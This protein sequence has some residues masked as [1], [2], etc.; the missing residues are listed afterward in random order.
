MARSLFYQNDQIQEQ[1]GK[2]YWNNGIDPTF[3][4]S[5]VWYRPGS[6]DSYLVWLGSKTYYVPDGTAAL[7]IKAFVEATLPPDIVHIILI[8]EAT[9]TV[10]I[11]DFG[12]DLPAEWNIELYNFGNIQG[13]KGT[14]SVNGGT[15][16]WLHRPVTVK[17][18]GTIAAGGGHGGRGG[19]GKDGPNVLSAGYWWT[20]YSSNSYYRHWNCEGTLTSPWTGSYNAVYR[21]VCKYCGGGGSTG[22]YNPCFR[23]YTDC[24]TYEPYPRIYEAGVELRRFWEEDAP[25]D[26]N[27]NGTWD[28]GWV[29]V[30]DLRL[31]VW[32]AEYWSG[33]GQGGDGGAGGDGAGFEDQA[34]IAGSA[35]TDGTCVYSSCGGD[36]GTG[37]NGGNFGDAGKVGNAASDGGTYRINYGRSS[38][39]L[40]IVGWA[41]FALADSIQGATLGAVV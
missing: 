38:A 31:R 33:G 9:S 23:W 10:G 13:T 40:A 32:Q 11:L 19:D 16:L 26:Y 29:E 21:G 35:G 1:G 6:G 7:D 27:P 15:A 14:Y 18:Y 39:G 37:G 17:N 22:S 24:P 30:I 25:C 2:V 4:L 36:G 8:V 34:L 5:S 12:T 41:E 20:D 3:D 28:G